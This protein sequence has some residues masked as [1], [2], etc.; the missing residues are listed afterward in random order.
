MGSRKKYCNITR[1]LIVVVVVV[2]VD[3]CRS[4]VD[5]TSPAALPTDDLD[6]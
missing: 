5:G 3:V 6:L 1:G 4:R 2:V